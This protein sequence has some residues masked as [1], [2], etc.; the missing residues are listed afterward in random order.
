VEAGGGAFRVSFTPESPEAL[1]H[2][3]SQADALAVDSL[4][5]DRRD[6]DPTGPD[7]SGE[8]V[9]I[10]P[11]AFR[12]QAQRL[13]DYREL[14]GLSSYVITLEDLHDEFA[15]GIADPWAVNAFLAYAAENWSVP[16]HYVVLVGKGTYDPKDNLGHGDNVLT[17]VLAATPYGMA[18]ADSLLADITGDRKL[19]FALGRIPV[20]TPAELDLYVDKIIAFEAG[21]GAWRNEALLLADDPDAAGDFTA[22]SETASTHLPAETELSRAYLEDLSVADARTAMFDAWTS[23]KRIVN[24]VGHGGVTVLAGEQLLHADE[25][26][27]VLGGT[28]MPAI[29]SALSCVVGRFE[30][31]G[32]QALSEALVLTEDGGAVTAWAPTSPSLSGAAMGLNQSYFDL[33]SEPGQRVGDATMGAIQAAGPTSP[34][35]LLETFTLIGDPGLR[36]D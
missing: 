12:E 15:G 28:G 11:S 26:D 24:Y 33:L 13:A 4:A 17:P 30:L 10:A 32:W 22:Q 20:L 27:S 16:P 9:V 18:A 6:S 19:D 2:V 1:Y 36:A 31:A 8:Y 23:G 29:F 5:A 21:S 35:F 14:T 34:Q 25:V 7:A 3:G